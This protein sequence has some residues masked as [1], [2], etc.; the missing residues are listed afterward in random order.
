M[1]FCTEFLDG[2]WSWEPLRRS[3]VRCG[4]CR[5]PSAPYVP[6]TC[7]AKNTLIKLPCCI[8]LAFQIISIWGTFTSLSE[9]S[10]CG[11]VVQN[12]VQSCTDVLETHNDDRFRMCLT[13]KHTTKTHVAITLK[14]AIRNQFH[15]CRYGD[16][17]SS[18]VTVTIVTEGLWF[19]SQQ[20]QK[21]FLC[22]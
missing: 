2:W 22:S 14:S 18:V 7:R 15:I 13:F 3:C 16:R 12:I 5:V 21:A 17:D 19:H 9:G 10:Y 6:E 20:E 4:W 11:P 1:V 8:K